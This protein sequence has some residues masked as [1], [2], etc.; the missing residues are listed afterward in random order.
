MVNILA[1]W[2]QMG[3]FFYESGFSEML[4]LISD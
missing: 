2:T 3:K 1:T 4:I